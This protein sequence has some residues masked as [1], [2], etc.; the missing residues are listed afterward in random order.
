M[1]YARVNSCNKQFTVTT[2]TN[3]PL[4]VGERWW[5]LNVKDAFVYAEWLLHDR[6]AP[7]L[8]TEAKN[9]LVA[10][11]KGLFVYLAAVG[12]RLPPRI[13]TLDLLKQLP[14]TLGGLYLE[15]FKLQRRLEGVQLQTLLLLGV[16]VLRFL[17]LAACLV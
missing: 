1:F 12:E 10:A 11:S 7:E 3:A 8:L 5:G 15:F 9:T 14:D 6:V 17:S 13:E 2:T 4:Q 16:S